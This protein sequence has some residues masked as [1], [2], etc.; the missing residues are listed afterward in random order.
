VK[1]I[2]KGERAILQEF[3]LIKKREERNKLLR[4]NN[5]T[6]IE[7]INEKKRQEAIELT[8]K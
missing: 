6:A 2:L 1:K 5:Q 7:A 4:F 8:Q 3:D